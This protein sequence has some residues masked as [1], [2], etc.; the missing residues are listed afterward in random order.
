MC[1]KG[2][3]FSSVF[4]SDSECSRIRRDI[5]DGLLPM[6][7]IGLSNIHKAHYV[8]GLCSSLGKKCLVIC[9]TEGAA[10]K[11]VEDLN[12]F[13]EK[14]FLY[15]RREFNFNTRATDSKEFQHQRLGVLSRIL[16]GSFRYIVTTLEAA[17]QFTMPPGELRRRSLVVSEGAEQSPS[18]LVETL[19]FAGYSR[20]DVV[21]A[22][23]QF[24]SRGEVLDFF[25]PDCEEPVR[26]EFWGDEINLLSHFDAETQRRTQRLG[27]IKITPSAEVI[28]DSRSL[29]DGLLSFMG[30]YKKKNAAAVKQKLASDLERLENGLELPCIDK[31]LS[32][33]YSERAT[34]FDYFD[35]D[36][37]LFVTESRAVRL[38]FERWAKEQNEE[39][40]QNKKDGELASGLDEF[41]LD[42][43]KAVE[44]YEALGAI[45]TDNFERGRFDTDYIKSLH[46]VTDAKTNA[47]WNGTVA[48]L[49]EDLELARSAGYAVCVVAGTEKMAK[50]VADDL[51]DS[52]TEALFF[53]HPPESFSSSVVTVLPG[54]LSGGFEYESERFTL[55][56]YRRGYMNAPKRKRNTTTG[57]TR[58][59]NLP[60]IS[61]EEIKPGDYVV[62]TNYGIGV[63]TGITTKTVEGVRADYLSIR[64]SDGE[65]FVPVEK[66]N[67]LTRYMSPEN[68]DKEVKLNSF[69]STKVWE[70]TKAKALESV[71]EVARD[72]ANVY[73]RRLNETGHAFGA[74]DDL[75]NLFELKFEYEETEDQIHAIN[76]VKRDMQSIHPMDRLLLGDVGY[77]KT[78]VALRGAFKCV[79]EGKQCAVLV[80]TTI[81]ALQHYQT[82]AK[83]FEGFAINVEMLSRF[84]TSA[85]KS[86]IKKDVKAGLIDILVGT[87]G[88]IAD[89][90]EFKDLGLLII[91]EEQRFGVK[92]KE[93]IKQRFPLVDVL[94][95]SATPIPRTLNMAMSGIRDMSL[96]EMPPQDRHAVQT[97]V[98]EHDMAFLAKVMEREINR[99]G[100]VYYLHNRVEDI[101]KRAEEI[102]RYLPDARIG[103]GH[104]KMKEE[105]LS[106]VWRSLLDGEIDILVCTTIIETGVD[107]P[108]A[109]TLIVEDA[110]RLGLAQLHQIRGRVGRS[111][112][113]AFA[114]F[115]YRKDKVIS[116]TAQSRLQAIEQYTGFGAGYHI[117][118]RD[119][120]IRGAGEILGTQ[121]HGHMTAVG[122]DMYIKML[123]DA[124]EELGATQRVKA[125]TPCRIQV[126]MDMSIP[127]T[128]IPSYANR[129]EIYKRILAISSTEDARDVLDEV[130]DR[131]GN[132]I[133]GGQNTG[134]VP[135]CVI[136]LIKYSELK[137]R[138]T[139]QNISEIR[140]SG[141]FI[142]VYADKISVK[143]AML[144]KALYKDR[145]VIDMDGLRQCMKIPLRGAAQALL[146]IERAIKCFETF[147]AQE[148][149]AED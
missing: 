149:Q 35:G 145:C 104:G 78:E 143:H 68:A 37:L 125:R 41:N 71:R 16:D 66:I 90:V 61:L 123:N 102:H 88:L 17:S 101:E 20:S 36:G 118:M 65:L 45:F 2:F 107:V 76:D 115:T 95:I 98:M 50:N 137:A 54:A 52:G 81:L 23:G 116:D 103:I 6:G 3:M 108:N 92:Q 139:A 51:T 131:F 15:P 58:Q 127:D 85:Q 106:D 44:Y 55:I 113:R 83:R 148:A 57:G 38:N 25:P 48:S 10:S 73:S 14:A 49:K 133:K 43:K 99:G 53:D 47:A 56:S 60:G 147:S 87:H 82:I 122:Y 105:E 39:I 34:L 74:D 80:P 93:K 117:A 4:S 19:M 141:R 121:Q 69:N 24:S 18:S 33:V 109:N 11:F 59:R 67:L 77:G 7:V 134:S 13:D 42:F 75:Q 111:A 89:S 64:Y 28:T 129:I 9:D 110:N 72:L 114:Y 26:A 126:S 31:Y 128:Y 27:S 8:S 22:H 100:Q 40:R 86:K 79:E 12:F 1:V 140:Q 130:T 63:F 124:V 135:K 138:A 91:D 84:R 96:L 29:A 97:T 46:R 120:E 32:V 94:T 132:E 136:D 144:M 21:E 112:R 70:R 62:H 30:A 142:A 146:V 5:S 119:L